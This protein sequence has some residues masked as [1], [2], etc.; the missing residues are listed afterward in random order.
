MMYGWMAFCLVLPGTS[1][2]MIHNTVHSLCLED[3]KTGWV[4]L[5]KCSLDSDLQ[6]WVWRDPNILQSVVTSRCL[7]GYHADPVQTVPCE[8]GE[9]GGEREGYGL[10]WDCEGNRL[11][12]RNLSLE[13]STDGKRLTL[14][15]RSKQSKWR[16]LDEGDICQE[17]L[18]SKRASS[19][20]KDEFE[21]REGGEEMSAAAMTEEQREFLKWFYRTED[22]MTWKLA[23]LA[24]SFGALLLGC[25][26]LG[27]GSMANKN[28]KKIAKYKAAASL[29]QRPEGEELQVLTTVTEINATHSTPTQV[30]TLSES[31]VQQ[32]QPQQDSG[33]TDRLKPG[34]IMVTWKNG[35]VSN[36]YPEPAAEL[37]EEEEERQE[38][39]TEVVETEEVEKKEEE[40][41]MEVEEEEAEAAVLMGE[42]EGQ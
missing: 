1:S 29:A 32:I 33:D 38:V 11:M 39:E 40:V 28:R 2:F 27:M 9:E 19:D 35:D 6:Q 17:R 18:R 12:S 41:E 14:S 4:Q 15:P 36:L 42:K 7:S 20:E 34:E 13:L 31:V 3:S 30:R 16:S 22:P 5:K 24:L 26:L 8:G 25:L 10:Q 21:V 23:M 37:E